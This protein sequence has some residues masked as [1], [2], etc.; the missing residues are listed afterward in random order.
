MDC[1]LCRRS[2][3]EAIV[4]NVPALPRLVFDQAARV[5][6][7]GWL[8]ADAAGCGVATARVELGWTPQSLLQTAPASGPA[9]SLAL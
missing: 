6:A 3:G 4:L 8:L 7:A 9:A 1:R 5:L 2:A